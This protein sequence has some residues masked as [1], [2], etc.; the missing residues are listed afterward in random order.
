MA[1]LKPE[2][3]IALLIPIVVIQLGLMIAALVDL[4]RDER[5][6]RGGSKLVWAVVIVFVNILG[7]I[8]YFIAG[9]EES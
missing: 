9:R 6:V 3:I 7:P 4:E 8:L 2:Q 5:R 1:P